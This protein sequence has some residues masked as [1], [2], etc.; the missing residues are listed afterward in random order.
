VRVCLKKVSGEIFMSDLKMLFQPGQIN[1]MVTRNRIVMSSAT[2]NSDLPDGRLSAQ[3]IAYYVERGQGG[4]GIVNTGYSFVCQRGKA[5][6]Y[7]MSSA[8]DDMIASM[9]SLTE[10]F[11]AAAPEGKIGSQLCHAGRITS[12]H[13]TGMQLEAPSPVAISHHPENVPEEMNVARIHEVIDLFSQSARRSK[14]G[15]FDLVE[16]HAGHGYL[17][18]QFISPFGN[19]RTDAYGGSMENRL[20]ILLETLEA[21]RGKVGRDFP[22]GVRI[23][24][25]DMVDG[26]YTLEDYQQVAQRIE[27]SSLVDYISITAGQHHPDAYAMMV[28]PMAIP[29]GF[30]EYLGAGIRSV[31]EKVPVFV[32]GR[33]KDPVLAEGIL[34][35]GSADYVVMT[36]ALMADPELPNK[37][38]HGQLEDIRPCIACMQGC[39]DRKRAELDLTCL[40]NPVAGRESEWAQLKPAQLKKRVLVVGGGPAGMEAARV[41]ALRNHA[42]TL[43]EKSSQLGGTALLAAIPPHREEFADL[44]RWLSRQIQAV[45]VQVE[46]GKKADVESVRKFAPDVLIAATGAQVEIPEN[47][48]GWNLPHVTN[49]RAALAGT[50]PI[51]K[52]VLLIGSDSQVIETAGWLVEQGKTVY[53]ISAYPTQ[54]GE[55]PLAGVA[56][57]K[58]GFTARQLMMNEILEKIH[59]LPFK[60]VKSIEPG[61]VILSGVGEAYP[62][63]TH[64]R[65]DRLEDERLEVDT[66]IIHLRQRPVNAWLGTL[67]EELPEVYKIGDC[68]EP[69]Q[70][71]DA[72]AEGARIG[73][74]I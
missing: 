12:H 60:M 26:G 15:G 67:Q 36:R 30:L 18:G 21:V 55:D 14:A 25:D 10:A 46:L 41:A 27:R 49:I 3:T 68:L 59:P 57:E 35:R 22:V 37:A 58:N 11:H 32:V 7:Q 64:M 2:T 74:L 50:V 42:V 53:W 28:A 65:I 54:N 52:R 71:I 44:P 56:N 9:Q 45:G 43:W 20:R 6:K 23:N 63:T 33:I 31:V 38:Q 48:P 47:I 1:Q 4:A 19:F 29:M 66:V 61:A 51:G 69:R 13:F 17:L 73:R 39:A 16:L 8:T 40:V 70:A 62:C 72:M 34:E 5:G 24:G